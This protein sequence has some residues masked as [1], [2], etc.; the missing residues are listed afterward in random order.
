MDSKAW[1][2]FKSR[3]KDTTSE[4][5]R[6]NGKDGKIRLMKGLRQNSQKMTSTWS[7]CYQPGGGLT[8]CQNLKV[9]GGGKGH[10]RE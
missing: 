1:L 7:C 4:S 2:S 5:M 9:R 6:A 8:R 3:S 10:K